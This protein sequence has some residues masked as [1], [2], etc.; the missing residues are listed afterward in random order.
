[1][2]DYIQNR[3]FHRNDLLKSMVDEISL[4]KNVIVILDE[5]HIAASEEQTLHVLFR[6]SSLLSKRYLY[7]N[8][9]KFIELSATPDGTIYDVMKW[10][11]A[12]AIIISEV[13]EGYVSSK[14]LLDQGR[15][16]QC[17]D[18]CGYDKKTDKV[19]P[20]VFENIGEIKKDVDSHHSS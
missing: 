4:K 2:P 1:M 14:D 3:V 16:K 8:D 18:L 6:K 11:E 10:E 12:S 9:I 5:N 13:G 20:I 15:V 19:K 17:K 7:D